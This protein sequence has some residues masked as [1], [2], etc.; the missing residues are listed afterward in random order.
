M[1]YDELEE[2]IRSNRSSFDQDEPPAGIWDRIAEMPARK[3]APK[4][5]IWKAFLKVA[6][7]FAVLMACTL[8]F[9]NNFFSYISEQ[10]FIERQL[11]EDFHTIEG[12]YKQEIQTILNRLADLGYSYTVKDNLTEIDQA[13]E[14]LKKEYVYAV[15]GT[16]DE[17]ISNVISSYQMKLKIVRRVL[18][19]IEPVEPAWTNVIHDETTF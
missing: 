4:F 5:K 18:D 17:I 12:H 6:A 8:S 2:Y 10:A 14:D 16:K 1:Q 13:I 7:T 3:K 19:R 9:G 15:A 11:P